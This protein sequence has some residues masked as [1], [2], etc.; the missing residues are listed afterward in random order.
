MADAIDRAQER[1]AQ[2]LAE[3]LARRQQLPD[4]PAGM[5]IGNVYCI[6]CGILIPEARLAALP[7]ACRCIR[8]Q[9]EA[10]AHA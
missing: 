8:C 3:S 2:F 5:A 7:G 6:D 9:E 10:D 4:V 1:E